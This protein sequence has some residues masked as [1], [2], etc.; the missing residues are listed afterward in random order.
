MINFK[1]DPRNVDKQNNFVTTAE[2]RKKEPVL[3]RDLQAN[4]TILNLPKFACILHKM[5][6]I[7]WT[8][9]S[10]APKLAITGNG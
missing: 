7:G 9:S 5:V 8:S 6:S 2:E 1:K 4:P 10:N 3:W